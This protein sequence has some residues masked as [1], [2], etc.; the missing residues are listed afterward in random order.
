MA[1][2]ELH[3]EVGVHRREVIVGHLASVGHRRA[4]LLQQPLLEEC[5][6]LGLKQEVLVC[7]SLDLDRLLNDVMLEADAH[8]NDEMVPLF[9]VLEKVGHFAA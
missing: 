2:G 1:V 7:F 3:R 8:M 9:A 4:H 6:E 5:V